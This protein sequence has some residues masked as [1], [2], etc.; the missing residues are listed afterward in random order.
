MF[1]SL[2]LSPN[3]PNFIILH[4]TQNFFIGLK[5]TT[6]LSTKLFLYKAL[7]TF[8]VIIFVLKHNCSTRSCSLTIHNPLSVNSGLQITRR[9]FY[10]MAPALWNSLPPDIRRLSSQFASS[11]PDISLSFLLCLLQWRKLV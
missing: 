3:F 6:E 10:Y 9:S 11:R 5:L 8:A 1:L 4:L 2:V 7:H